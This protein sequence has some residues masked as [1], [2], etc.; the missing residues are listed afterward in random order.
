MR[1]YGVTQN[2][3]DINC[4]KNITTITECKSLLLTWKGNG[5]REEKRFTAATKDGSMGMLSSWLISMHLLIS[6]I[7]CDSISTI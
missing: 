4:N 5:S 3:I 2:K 1:C 7:C 6:T